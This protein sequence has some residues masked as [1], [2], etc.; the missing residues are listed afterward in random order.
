VNSPIFAYDA[1]ASFGIGIRLR[2]W[3]HNQ[4]EFH[5]AGQ[6][7]VSRSDDDSM[8]EEV[9]ERVLAAA[10]DE[11]TRWGIDRFRIVSL[12][13]RHGLDPSAI[14]QEWGNEET[15]MLEIFLAWPSKQ[16]TAPD[17]GS[18]RTDLLALVTGMAYYVQSEIGRRL[19]ITHIIDNPDLPSARIR[20]EVWRAR[21]GT[22]R[23]V[24]DRARQRGE[25]RDG[26]DSLTVLELLFAPINM[27]ALFTGEPV[28]HEYC[29]TI[30]ELVWRAI[31][32]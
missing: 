24:V 13:D 27:R 18:I 3:F 32:Q 8:P 25:L 1:A 17:T 26:V 5:M 12:A 29:R 16:V 4:D 20:R 15:L 23:I 9:R 31:T 21:S 30:S 6:V 2:K 7:A 11:L 28:D 22:L 10:Y 19:Q 14:R